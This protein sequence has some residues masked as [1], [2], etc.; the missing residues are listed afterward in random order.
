MLLRHTAPAV[1][2][3]FGRANLSAKFHAIMHQLFLLSPDVATFAQLVKDVPVWLSDQGTESGIARIEPITVENVLS[4]VRPDDDDEEAP[5]LATT[6]L[7]PGPGGLET[8]G[9][10]EGKRFQEVPCSDPRGCMSESAGES[11]RG[12]RSLLLSC[13]MEG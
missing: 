13:S 2:L 3:G 6:G 11:G 4:Y 10:G 9:K 5:C 7:S 1:H 12:F 8:W